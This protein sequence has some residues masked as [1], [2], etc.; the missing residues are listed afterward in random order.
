M[1]NKKKSNS[2][3]K[4]FLLLLFYV[5]KFILFENLFGKT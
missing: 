5:E 2:N 1:K 3:N 4:H